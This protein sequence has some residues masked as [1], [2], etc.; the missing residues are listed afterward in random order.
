MKFIVALLAVLCLLIGACS[1]DTASMDTSPIV[2]MGVEDA[3]GEGVVGGDG[4]VLT[5]TQL[6]DAGE[7]VTEPVTDAG[8][9]PD[10]GEDQ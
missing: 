2:E 7:D 6:W 1:D 4:T 9:E 8:P 10:Q 3:A 5:D